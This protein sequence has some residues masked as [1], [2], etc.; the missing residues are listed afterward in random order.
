MDAAGG[1]GRPARSC[2]GAGSEEARAQRAPRGL[3]CPWGAGDG[4]GDAGRPWTPLRSHSR[5]W[6]TP[7]RTSP[8][9]PVS[10]A[11]RAGGAAGL[12]SSHLRG[13]SRPPTFPRVT[14]DPLCSQRRVLGRALDGSDQLSVCCQSSWAGIG[15]AFPVGRFLCALSCALTA[16]R[17]AGPGS[18]QSAGAR[19]LSNRL[20]RVAGGWPSRSGPQLCQVQSS[21]A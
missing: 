11:G 3:G 1:G 2:R 14:S 16:V 18:P 17:W 21:C 7:W 19:P 9:S 6:S 12:G 20:V 10:A 5:R 4:A 15:P 13:H 8:S